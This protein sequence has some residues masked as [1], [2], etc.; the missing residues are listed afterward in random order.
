MW[1]HVNAN[2][3][4]PLCRM[5]ELRWLQY[6]PFPAGSKADRAC[7]YLHRSERLAVQ[8]ANIS[9]TEIV[10]LCSSS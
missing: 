4:H 9:Q 10:T 5:F 3:V 1:G 7:S 6:V 8:C 2:C